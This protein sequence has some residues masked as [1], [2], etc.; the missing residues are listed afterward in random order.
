MFFF[1]GKVGVGCLY[2]SDHFAVWLV[3]LILFFLHEGLSDTWWIHSSW[4]APRNKQKGAHITVSSPPNPLCHLFSF[5]SS[6][7]P[8]SLLPYLFL[9]LIWR[10]QLW[11]QPW[12]HSY[13]LIPGYFV[14]FFLFCFVLNIE[15]TQ[16][17]LLLFFFKMQIIWLKEFGHIADFCFN[18]Q[19]IIERMGELEKLEWDYSEC[20]RSAIC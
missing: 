8:I 4:W 14:T 16:Y 11:H 9:P 12:S 10:G 19:A 18:L 5:S 7:S 17:G 15:A 1:V 3:V 20:F 6:F 13:R 2:C